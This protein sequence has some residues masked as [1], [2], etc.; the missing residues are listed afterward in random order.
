MHSLKKEGQR[1]SKYHLFAS[2]LCFLTYNTGLRLYAPFKLRPTA[3]MVRFRMG[4]SSWELVQNEFVL[5]PPKLCYALN[6]R[7]SSL[8]WAP[9]PNLQIPLH[10]LISSP[11]EILT[12]SSPTAT[13]GQFSY[14]LD[15]L[16]IHIVLSL[17][18]WKSCNHWSPS[19]EVT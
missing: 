19:D 18:Y 4:S 3:W 10:N 6:C 14:L 16:L 13:S 11:L 17:Y 9:S 12:Q 15:L 5:A 1:S 8:L 2:V 7:S